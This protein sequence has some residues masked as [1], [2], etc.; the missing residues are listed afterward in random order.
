MA[1]FSRSAI[2]TY[3]RCPRQYKAKYVD[4]TPDPSGPAAQVGIALHKA[5]EDYAEFLF[6]QHSRSDKEAF[7]HICEREFADLPPEQSLDARHVAAEFA[8][9]YVMLLDYVHGLEITLDTPLP[10]GDVATGRLDR[11]DIVLEERAVM[12]DYKT[13]RYVPPSSEMATDFQNL[14]YG[15]LVRENFPQVAEIA[16]AHLFVRYGAV[17]DAVLD[18]SDIDWVADYAA[19]AAASIKA[20]ENWIPKSGT[21]CSFCP[22]LFTCVNEGTCPEN[23]IS[24]DVAV[25][26]HAWASAILGRV[27]PQ[28]RE[29]AKDEP[30]PYD[31]QNL[32]GFWDSKTTSYK[33][34]MVLAVCTGLGID[35]ADFL[36]AKVTAVNKLAKRTDEWG[37]M[38]REAKVIKTGTRFGKRARAKETNEETQEEVSND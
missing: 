12:H 32:I 33:T 7:R 8:D 5:V 15:W 4:R 6:Q 34:E 3:R 10:D 9:S 19:R 31:E 29:A 36:Q 18:P 25:Q 17:R 28:I 2:E 16:V 13:G 24:L 22:N 20:D 38:V 26:W 1:R 30:V 23:N 11:L 14:F 35:F 27:E 21:W 37:R